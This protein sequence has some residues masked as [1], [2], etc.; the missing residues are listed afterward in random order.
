[1][2]SHLTEL[3]L[4]LLAGLVASVRNTE[5]TRALITAELLSALIGIVFSGLAY[6]IWD[7]L[8]AWNVFSVAVLLVLFAQ[9]KRKAG[10]SPKASTREEWLKSV[11]NPDFWP[12]LGP[13]GGAG[14]FG[15][16]P[17][18][19]RIGLAFWG[20]VAGSFIVFRLVSF[21]VP[22]LGIDRLLLVLLIFILAVNRS[23]Y[24][25]KENW[26]KELTAP[27]QPEW[28]KIFSTSDFW[29]TMFRWNKSRTL[30][31][32]PIAWLQEYSWTARLTKW[33]WCIL[34]LAGELAALMTV[35]D[36][37]FVFYQSRLNILVLVGLAFSAS[38]SFRRERQ[39]G[40]LELLLVTPLQARQL[41]G[42]RLWGVWGHFLPALAILYA[43]WLM[44]PYQHNQLRSFWLV[45]GLSSFLWLPVIGLYFSLL[46]MNFLVAWLTT[47]GVGLLVPWVA[48]MTLARFYFAAGIGIEVLCVWQAL[49]ALMAGMQL[50]ENLSRRQFSFQ[51]VTS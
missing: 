22:L 44:A 5:W 7:W 48:T 4:A 24:Q 20:A 34:V 36:Q 6:L 51:T 37:R 9:L 21:R 2:L 47:C 30:D 32:N 29:Q 41:I 16:I 11:L 25:L 35:T 46:R 1:M 43:C 42:G 23:A 8:G 50:Y 3:L 31:R 49:T 26:Q 19:W 13:W 12:E 10:D 15:Q 33:G 28:V 38:G 17:K 40:A 39:S 14:L 45:F 18:A 27:P